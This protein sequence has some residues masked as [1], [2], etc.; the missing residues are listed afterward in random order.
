MSKS[1]WIKSI[2]DTKKAEQ[3]ALPFTRDN[4]TKTA[5]RLKAA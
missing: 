4:R 1:R 3:V 5:E 2:T